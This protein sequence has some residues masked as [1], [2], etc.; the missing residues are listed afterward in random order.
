MPWGTHDQ[1]LHVT[2]KRLRQEEGV[3]QLHRCTGSI[4]RLKRET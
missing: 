3:E 1:M 4:G 2:P